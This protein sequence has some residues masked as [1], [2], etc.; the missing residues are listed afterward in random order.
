[1][2]KP[3]K[4]ATGGQKNVTPKDKPKFINIVKGALKGDPK[5]LNLMSSGLDAN[6]NGVGLTIPADVQTAINT[7]KQTFTSLEP[8]V[9]VEGVSAPSGSRVIEPRQS[10]TPFANLDDETAQIGNNDEPAAFKPL[11]YK[12]HRYAGISSITNTLMNDS[13]ANLLAYLENWIAKKDVITRNSEILKA[14]AKLPSAQKTTVDSFDVIK[15]IYNK[16]LDPL[17]WNESAFVTNQ[18]G[19]AVLD[20]VKDNNGQYVIQPNP[21]NPSQKMLAGK[22]ITVIADAF[23]PNDGNSFPL[24]IGALTE[25]VRLFDLQQ[26][27]LLATN[28]GAGSFENDLTKIR[29]IDRFD[30][31]LWDT[32]SV[33]YAPFTGLAD[34]APAA[35]TSGTTSSTG[36]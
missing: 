17:I 3:G 4:P 26:M 32:E 27:S 6:G 12:I 11:T 16:E 25:A 29:A 20:K 22:T 15:D 35:K 28:I 10:V 33:I 5:F 23:L 34:L 21:L 31:E 36:K 9:T 18:S 7:L 24:Y 30:V 13:D 1:M 19:F 8:L 2:A 14:L